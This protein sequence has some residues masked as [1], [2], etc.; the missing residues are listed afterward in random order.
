MP[1]VELELRRAQQGDRRPRGALGL[2]GERAQLA[3][4]GAAL[5]PAALV[6]ADRLER[7]VRFEQPQI[8]FR[9]QRD[10]APIAA[11]GE[12][13]LVVGAR[14]VGGL[15][16]EACGF[17]ARVAARQVARDDRRREPLAERRA[18]QVLA[19]RAMHAHA[20]PAI[21]RAVGDVARQRMAHVDRVRA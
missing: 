19:E 5:A 21:E 20:A 14:G 9:D 12:L 2:A 10:H 16:I 4:V 17:L 3:E 8:A 7:L 13:R 15:Q 18:G 11:L 1:G 6:A